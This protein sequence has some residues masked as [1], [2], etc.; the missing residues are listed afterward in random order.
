VPLGRLGEPEEVA[1]LIAF[2]ASPAGGYVTGTTIV[3]DGGADAW[4]AGYPAP[5]AEPPPT[6]ASPAAAPA[7]PPP[8]EPTIEPP[9]GT[10]Q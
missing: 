4:G 2:L 6:S 10:T 5:T 8:A 3:V 9:G 7:E 1:G